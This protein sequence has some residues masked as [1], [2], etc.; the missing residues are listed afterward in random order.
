MID[1]SQKELKDF[2]FTTKFI[3]RLTDESQKELK[4]ELFELFQCLFSLL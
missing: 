2:A 3:D 4:A 1:E